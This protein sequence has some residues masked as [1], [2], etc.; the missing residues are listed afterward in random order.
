MRTIPIVVG[1]ITLFFV[2]PQA[3]GADRLPDI[4]VNPLFLNHPTSASHRYEFV[5]NI[6]PGRV[7]L[8]LSNSTP[9]I[10]EGPLFIYGGEESGNGQVVYQRIFQTEGG[11]RDRP[12]GLFVFHP[13]HNHVHVNRWAE[14]RIRAVLPGDG[15]GPVLRTGG[16]TSF[17]LLDSLRYQG[18][19]PV[20]GN[21]PALPVFRTCG[22]DAQ[23]ISVGF[24]DLYSK[25]LPDQWID[26]TGLGEG[27]YWLESVVDPDNQFEEIDETN[28]VARIK[29]IIG[30]GDMPVPDEI[31]IERG[32]PWYAA[33]V[34]VLACAGGLALRAGR[35]GSKAT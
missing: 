20:L 3:Y 25:T 10:G 1:A 35:R 8:R 28:N 2:A 33:I 6:I 31:P 16:K 7:H 18:P 14:Y 19:E 13:A 15:V 21:V 34:L 11:F 12:A 26:V 22:N 27:E 23:G 9:N 32:V 4:I 5:T 30:P 29:L 17:C 24:E